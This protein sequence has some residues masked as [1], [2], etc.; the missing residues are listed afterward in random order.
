[1][2]KWKFNS[3][4]QS[5]NTKWKCK[6]WMINLQ[7]KVRSLNGQKGKFCLYQKPIVPETWSSEIRTKSWSC[8]V[9]E[10]DKLLQLRQY[11]SGEAPKATENLN[12]S[13]AKLLPFFLH[14][15]LGTT[16]FVCWEKKFSYHICYEN[17]V[18]HSRVKR[19]TDRTEQ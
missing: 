10:K 3:L 1:M 4:N 6:C 13:R 16:K 18:K 14:E 15:L 5:K 7:V 17:L 12:H 2:K 19:H 8:C 9:Q 11:L